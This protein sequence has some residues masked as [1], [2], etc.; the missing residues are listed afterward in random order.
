MRNADKHYINKLR[1]D[2]A[3]K[4]CISVDSTTGRLIYQRFCV[5]CHNTF[6]TTR[7]DKLTDNASCSRQLRNLLYNNLKLPL[8]IDVARKKYI[9]NN[10]E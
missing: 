4:N 8:D 10:K 5:I 6:S 9:Y 3:D 2:L 1:K 7:R